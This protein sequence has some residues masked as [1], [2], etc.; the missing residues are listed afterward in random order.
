MKANKKDLSKL[1]K[2]LDK[3]IIIGASGG[4]VGD[5]KQRLITLTAC[6]VHDECQVPCLVHLNAIFRELQEI[7][8]MCKS[9]GEKNRLKRFLKS[10]DYKQRIQDIQNSIASHIHQFTVRR[11]G[12]YQ[13]IILILL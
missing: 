11:P 10:K 12:C 9:V 3:L 1:E 6:I 8:L 2:S 5:L 13:C 4:E 7:A